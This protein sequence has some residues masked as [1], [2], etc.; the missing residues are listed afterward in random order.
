MNYAEDTE[1]A[2][3][4]VSGPDGNTTVEKLGNNQTRNTLNRSS[5]NWTDFDVV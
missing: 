2:T 1:K 5:Q 3:H 4:K